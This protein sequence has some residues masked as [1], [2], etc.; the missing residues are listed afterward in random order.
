MN[1]TKCLINNKGI[2]AQAVPTNEARRA[3]FERYARTRADEERKEKKAAQKA[4]IEGFRQLLEEAAEV[5][6]LFS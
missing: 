3:I 5:I 6:A 4:A 2:L 1:D